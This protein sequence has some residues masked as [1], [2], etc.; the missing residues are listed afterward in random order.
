MIYSLSSV[1]RAA[2]LYALQ[3]TYG[4]RVKAHKTER[5]SIQSQ[6]D[7]VTL[8]QPAMDSY[9]N[10]RV[11]NNE[12]LSISYANPRVSNPPLQDSLV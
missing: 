7:R 12:Q 11:Q 9:A 2:S 8:S 4:E 10:R 6:K 1:N 3:K 5:P